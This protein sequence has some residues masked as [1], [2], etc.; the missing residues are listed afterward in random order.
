MQYGYGYGAHIRARGASVPVAP[1]YEEPTEPPDEPPEGEP[2]PPTDTPVDP[3]TDEPE[4]GVDPVFAAPE[5]IELDGTKQTVIRTETDPNTWGNAYVAA[6][7]SGPEYWEIL[8]QNSTPKNATLAVGVSTLAMPLNGIPGA[9]PGTIAYWSDGNVWQDGEIIATLATYGRGDRIGVSYAYGGGVRFF[10]NC[11]AQN[12]GNAVGDVTGSPRYPFVGLYSSGTRT[13]FRFST[14]KFSCAV[15]V[16]FYP[17][18]QLPIRITAEGETR[19]DADGAIRV[20]VEGEDFDAPPSNSISIQGI[21]I[22]INSQ[23]VTI[24]A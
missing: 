24:G 15:P 16:G 17:I 9:L 21:A 6:A 13:A 11:V 14:S 8:V 10:K 18:G 22:Q 20:V 23:Y 1:A 19:V 7:L 12:S 2:D 4:P 3:V 5:R